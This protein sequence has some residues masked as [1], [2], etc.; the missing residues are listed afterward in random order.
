MSIKLVKEAKSL[1]LIFDTKLTFKNH[2]Q[3]LKSSCQKA[4]D[5]LHAVGHSDWGA[6]RIVLLCLCH[7]LDHS[8]LDYR[9]I[10]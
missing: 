2:V 5:I 6:N 4:L 9:S 10:V 1:G 7:A 3:Y 8:R